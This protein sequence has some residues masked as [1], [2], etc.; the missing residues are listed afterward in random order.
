MEE[1]SDSYSP[2][3]ILFRDEQIQ[4]IQ[5][6]YEYFSKDGSSN[7]IIIGSTGSGKTATIKKTLQKLDSKSYSYLSCGDM[8]TSKKIFRK[9]ANG[10]PFD[11]AIEKFKKEKKII[12]FDEINKVRDITQF[13]DDMNTFFR[14]TGC[15][16]IVITNKV[17]IR[18]K[19]HDDAKRTLWFSDVKFPPYN[20]LQIKEILVQRIQ[21]AKE[22]AKAIPE[23]PEETIPYIAALASNEDY[24]MRLALKIFYNSIIKKEFSKEQIEKVFNE[25]QT[26]ERLSWIDSLLQNEKNLLAF[27][28]SIILEKNENKIFN[29]ELRSKFQTFSKQR[30]SQ[31]LSKFEDLD[32]IKS[33]IVWEAGLKNKVI[34]FQSKEDIDALINYFESEGYPLENSQM[35]QKRL[36]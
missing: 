7:K 34:S 5:E 2:K 3:K 31:I 17:N 23:I 11:L 10:L 8:Q 28:I 6:V 13:F 19:M 20:S 1:L 27:M 35:I 25:I 12:I 16:F 22:N 4:K 36:A 32:L 24:S 30:L 9:L 33:E 26:R 21:E 14:E 18:R 15:S 29:E